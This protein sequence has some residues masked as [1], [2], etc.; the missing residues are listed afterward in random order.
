MPKSLNYLPQPVTIVSV[1]HNDTVNLTSVSHSPTLIMIA[2][3]TNRYSHELLTEAEDFCINILA[4]DQ[5]QLATK[6]GTVSGRKTDK[7]KMDIF[8]LTQGKINSPFI[9]D[10]LAHYECKKTGF[11]TA[12]DHTLFLGEIVDADINE[13]KSPLLLFRRKYYR[14]GEFIADYP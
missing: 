8:K 10:C 13:N 4:D 3:H 14:I 9:K 5:K 6:A 2:L 11:Y 7:S 1:K 12:G